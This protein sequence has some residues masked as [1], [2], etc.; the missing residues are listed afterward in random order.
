MTGD[1]TF[2][3]ASRSASGFSAE[4][5]SEGS[6]AQVWK[7]IEHQ[8]PAY[9][10]LWL[11]FFAKETVWLYEGQLDELVTMYQ[12]DVVVAV[13][14]TFPSV[15]EWPPDWT[16]EWG[17][18]WARSPDGVGA[19]SV[20]SPL[21]DGWEKLSWYLE[22]GLPRLGTRTN[23]LDRVA[24]A[25]AAS[26]D[27][28]LVGTTY[29]AVFERLRALR[30]A[31]NVLTDLYLHPQELGV[32]RDAVADEFVDQIRG[33]GARG[34]DA[35]L[36]ADDYGT[37]KSMLISPRH[38]RTFYQDCYARM[39]EEIHALG[40]HAWFHSCGY[41]RPIIPDLIEIGFDVLH[42]LQPS[43]MDLTE[44]AETFSGQICFAGAV[45]VQALLPSGSPQEV[46]R[47]IQRLI[48]LLSRPEGGYI[49]APTNSIMPDTPL[50]NIEAMFRAAWRYGGRGR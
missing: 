24:T 5:G 19:V 47:E 4:I 27:R 2:L 46:E 12:D 36:L 42:P 26:P 43:A 33:I 18:T 22:K 37:Q 38:W 13:L 45:D 41:I 48:G 40:M 34:A 28:Y 3:S 9:V 10:P 7:T 35:V 16:D 1:D 39:V 23:L 44:I 31:E 14:S 8:G 20:D 15:P 49:A 17:C 32:L 50:E 30:G 25:R 21:Q 6:R 29:L 11:N